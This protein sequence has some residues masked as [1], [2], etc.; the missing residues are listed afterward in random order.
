MTDSEPSQCL[1]SIFESKSTKDDSSQNEGAL[2]ANTIL[3]DQ[4]ATSLQ[5]NNAH[6]KTYRKDFKN[7]ASTEDGHLAIPEWKTSATDDSRLRTSISSTETLLGGTLTPADL[8]GNDAPQLREDQEPKSLGALNNTDSQSLPASDRS[9]LSPADW[10]ARSYDA[11]RESQYREPNR[12]PRFPTQEDFPRVSLIISEAIR[13]PD[14]PVQD[15][16]VFLPRYASSESSLKG[17]AS[18]LK[19]KNPES[20]LILLRGPQK[21][22]SEEQSYSWGDSDH[23][24]SN[25]FLE[26]FLLVLVTVIRKGLVEECGFQPRNIVIIG[27]GQGGTAALTMAAI[28]E[29]IEFGGIVSIGGPPSKAHRVSSKG[30]AKTPSLTFDDP[31]YCF[32]DEMQRRLAEDFICDHY[33]MQPFNDDGTLWSQEIEPS[34]PS[35]P[36]KPPQSSEPS[37]PYEPLE[38]LEPLFEFLAHRLRRDEWTKQAVISFG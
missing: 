23:E 6:K 22:S 10:L 38:P 30:R 11:L 2:C 4:P 17:L 29:R 18:R 21:I 8:E 3:P 27:L 5:Q 35:E 32:D 34:E 19:T 7:T 37:K 36:L 28:W 31:Q 16:I 33:D 1:S 14:K 12:S 26:S 24:H 25:E 20:A 13:E 9:A 15:C